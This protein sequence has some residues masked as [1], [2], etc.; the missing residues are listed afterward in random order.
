MLYFSFTRTSV[1]TVRYTITNKEKTLTKKSENNARNI[2]SHDNF[3]QM[4]MIYNNLVGLI[5]HK[6]I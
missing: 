3:T 6:C 4:Y 1:P 5:I 2:T